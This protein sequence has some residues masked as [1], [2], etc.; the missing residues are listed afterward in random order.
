[1]AFADNPAVAVT[2]PPR[3]VLSPGSTLVAEGGSAATLGISLSVAPSGNVTVNLAGGA[4]LSTSVSQLTFTPTNWNVVQT[5]SVQAIDDTVFEKQHTGTL[6]VTV[7]TAD[8]LYQALAA[9]TLMYTVSDN[10]TSNLGSVAGTLWSD[11]NKDGAVNLGESALV[12]WR[13]FDDVNRNGKLD[14]GEVSTSTDTSGRYRLDD[15]SPGAHTISTRIETGWSPTYPSLSGSSASIIV[16][17][18]GSSES[19]TGDLKSTELSATAA[20]ALYTNLGT[21]TN[22]AAFYADP[23]FSSINGQGVSVVVIDTGIDLDHPSFGA[24]SDGN[25]IADR[26]VFSYDFYGSNDSNASD[27]Q[28]HGTHVAGIVGSSDLTFPGIAQGVNIIALRVLGN[29]GSGSSADIL[30]AINWVVA[31]AARYNVVAVN[32]SLGGGT[33]D[34]VPTSG[35]ASTQFKALA[36]A[37]VVVVSASGNGYYKTPIQ[38]VSYPSSDPYSLSVGAV[39]AS[40]GTLGPQTGRTDAIAVFSQ[41][42]DTES[43]IFAPGVAISAAKNG[44]GYV[45]L[46]GTSMAAPEISGMVA[47]AQQLS[48][49]EL[50][51]RL[52]FDEIRSLLKSTGKSIVDGDDENDGSTP[53][54]GLTFYRADMLALAEAILA[55]KPAVSYT[56][57]I[58]N[59]GLVDGK[60]FGFSTVSAVQ[61]LAADDFIVGN[62]FGEIIGGGAGDDQ[63]DGGGGDDFISG[64]AGNDQ[65]T[66]GTGNDTVDG[67]DGNDTVIYL[68]NR[69]AYTIT[70]D[71]ASATYTVSSIAEGTDRVTKIE[72]FK[73]TNATVSASSVIDSTP[74]VLI[75]IDPADEATAVAIGANIIL[76]FNESVVARSGG[77]IELMTDYSSGHKSVEVFSV[78]DSTRVTISGKVVT[79]DPT[80]ALLPGTG[81]HLG[82]NNALADTAGN[83]FSYTHGQYNFTTTAAVIE[84]TIFGTTGND[85]LKGGAGNDTFD[86]GA[87]TDAAVF[88]GNRASYTISKTSTGWTVSSTAEGVDTLTNI[89]RLK[90][91]DAAIA[92]DT[93]EV[94][95]QAYRLYQAAFNRAPDLEG[96][97]YWI[98]RMDIGDSLKEVA[99][100]FV[101]SAEFKVVY[102]ASPTN[103]QIVTRF[104]DNVLHRAAESGGYNYWLGTLNSGQDTVAEVLASFSDSPENQA[105]VI[106]VIGNGILYTPFI[107]PT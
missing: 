17:A 38:G 102:G 71:S 107:S 39:W 64:E 21:A 62:E 20:N 63:I 29:D 24:D 78:S 85:I 77:T 32:L 58:T 75:S 48:L 104:Y 52:S 15:L 92:L 37:G 14:L 23:R 61:G 6:T 89:E 105:G 30:E 69:S 1:L 43:D 99:K 11:A 3:V 73:F 10:D 12:G 51:R 86:G 83:A 68:G 36:N 90:F 95:G 103:A 19:T 34:K 101:N 60:N 8:S 53:N 57:T 97:G 100:S 42:D 9:S 96:L 91:A 31:N 93:S 49:R 22:I 7:S 40:S 87:G 72:T 27:G 66:P 18:P 16:N 81:Y 47:L 2:N 82:F 88:S 4:Q 98:S 41:R 33:F 56:V 80:S 5:V 50:G 94:G 67:G 74:P 46:D 13:V 76:S 79:I 70:F 25:G 59:G 65:I 84:K 26:I 35:Y 44:G 106:G 28:G 45:A 54:T 55:M